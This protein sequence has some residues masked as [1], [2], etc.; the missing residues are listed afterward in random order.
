MFGREN[1]L[2]SFISSLREDYSYIL[3][4]CPP[5]LT[6]L[7]INALVAADSVL[8]P[9]Q[10]QHL[11]TAGLVELLKTVSMVRQQINP[12]LLIEGVLMTMCDGRTNMTKNTV[13]A[14]REAYSGHI[15]IFDTEIPMS[16]KA[17][18]AT[19]AGMSVFKYAPQCKLAAA[20]KSFV[21]ELASNGE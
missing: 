5:T 17:S 14:I 11:A 18:E 20:Y 4:D 10:A 19:C 8:I 13:E 21:K 16:V 6:M 15:R 9:V 2:K 7:T 1:K 3:I 12:A